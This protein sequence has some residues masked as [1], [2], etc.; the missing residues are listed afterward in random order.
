MPSIVPLGR[1]TPV[2]GEDGDPSARVVIRGLVATSF[3]GS[4]FDA[5]MHWDGASPASPPVPRTGGLFDLEAGGLRLVEARTERHEYV[6]APTGAP[7]AS[8]V[9]AGVASPC[10]VPRLASLARDRLRTAGELAPTLVGHVEQDDVP[11]PGPSAPG[12]AP[13]AALALA[14]GLAAALAAASVRRRLGRRPLSRVHAAGRAALRATR[15]DVTLA[16]LRAHVRAMVAHAVQLDV[17]RRACSR[18]LARIDRAALDRRHDACQRSSAAGAADTLAW[19]AAE[20][21][22]G[23]RLEDDLAASLLGI[24]RIESALRVLALRVRAPA[25]GGCATP[26]PVREAAEE[27]D[28]RDEALRDADLDAGHSRWNRRSPS[29]SRAAP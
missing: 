13:L 25:G 6:L 21:A 8:C 11:S 4:S 15:G 12:A 17:A 26:D 20:R 27:L 2:A 22:E 5:A 18:R 14:V 9:A 16:P 29:A 23:G 1:V 19:I 3:D 7:G 10:F 28:L 24:E